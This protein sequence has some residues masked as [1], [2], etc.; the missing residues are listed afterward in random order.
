MLSPLFCRWNHVCLDMIGRLN[1]LINKQHI[2]YVKWWFFVKT[3][4]ISWLQ[5]WNE[6]ENAITCVL[7]MIWI[8]LAFLWTIWL[9]SRNQIE[10]P[11]TCVFIDDENYF[12]VFWRIW[13]HFENQTENATMQHLFYELKNCHCP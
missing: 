10:N 5:F 7:E 13:L 4:E 1:V 9:Q 11:F 6:T 12:G 2:F 8:N 3:E